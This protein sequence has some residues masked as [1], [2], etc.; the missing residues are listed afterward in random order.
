M[1]GFL[2]AA[3]MVVRRRG[4][5]HQAKPLAAKATFNVLAKLSPNLHEV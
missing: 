1:V 5:S 2:G 4:I 3:R